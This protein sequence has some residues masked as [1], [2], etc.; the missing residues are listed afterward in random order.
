MESW[1]YNSVNFNCKD[2]NVWED[3]D[4]YLSFFSNKDFSYSNLFFNSLNS[5]SLLYNFLFH[6]DS[7]SLK[8]L[9]SYSYL[10]IWVLLSSMVFSNKEI[11]LFNDTILFVNSWLSLVADYN[12]F[13]KNN[14][15]DYLVFILD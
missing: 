9:I 12:E 4:C 3:V 5:K 8:Y 1:D 10:M 11:L 2:D 13:F 7:F 6:D 14:T 15:S